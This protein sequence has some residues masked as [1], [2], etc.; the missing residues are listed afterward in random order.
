MKG[1]RCSLEAMLAFQNHYVGKSEGERGKQVVKDDLKR[2]F[3][4]NKTTFYFENYLTKIN[5]TFN[6]LENC[7]VP[8]YE[9]DK[10]KQLLDHINFPNKYLKTE[11]NIF[12]SSHS[13]SFETALT[14]ISTVISHLFP[15]TQP[16]SGRYGQ[17]RQVNSAGIGEGGFR[18]GWFEGNVGHGSGGRGGRGG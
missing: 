7:N 18:D 6:M 11:V 16:S 3:Y 8:L 15:A 14:Y 13:A 2:L 9:E 5:Q 10:V 4:R 1:K 12:R 17:I